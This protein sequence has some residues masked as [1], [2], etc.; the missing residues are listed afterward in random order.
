MRL[1]RSPD[2]F[3][4]RGTTPPDHIIAQVA[5]LAG[6]TLKIKSFTTAPD[7][8]KVV[9]F[10]DFERNLLALIVYYQNHYSPRRQAFMSAAKRVLEAKEAV[11][12]LDKEIR[13]H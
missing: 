7:S 2:Y 10:P 13:S 5:E 11:L 1:I 3:D 4:Y 6:A 12:A 9:M 8:R